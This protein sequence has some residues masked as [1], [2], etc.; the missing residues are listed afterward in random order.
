MTLPRLSV[1]KDKYAIGRVLGEPGPF[2]IAYKAVDLKT[3]EQ[4]VIHEYFPQA[5]AARPEGE[6]EV[7]VAGGAEEA[8]AKGLQHFLA[9]SEVLQGL[10]HAN[11]MEELEIVEAN[12]TA[13]RVFRR[14]SG[15]TLAKGLAK[16]GGA[17]PERAARA[18]ILP[19]LDGLEA[20]H[21]RKVLHEGLCPENVVLA[22]SGQPV[23]THYRSALVRAAEKGKLLSKI[24]KAPYA[25]PEQYV[26]QSKQGPWTDVYGIASLYYRIVS[27][28]E[29]PSAKQRLRNDEVEALV[30][31][32]D[33]TSPVKTALKQALVLDPGKRLRTVAAFR[34]ALQA[35]GEQPEEPA[36][37]APSLEEKAKMEGAKMQA[38]RRKQSEQEQPA[39]GRVVTATSQSVRSRSGVPSSRGAASRSTS[40]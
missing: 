33:V 15:A 10:E 35:E 25:P 14:V 3:E 21:G 19:L 5:W 24:L 36:A 12:G 20:L 29:L 9:E 11:V 40:G 26:P 1:V 16:Q 2:D 37:L 27:G 38:R 4:V 18:I 39:P 6:M 22:K 17:L 8:F 30:D 7:E 23:L 32:L 34:K 31:A 28:K 13:Y